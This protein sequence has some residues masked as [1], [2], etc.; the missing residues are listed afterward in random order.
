[1]KT[2]II[3]LSKIII[4]L[5]IVV[6]FNQCKK[7]SPMITP[8]FD[9]ALFENAIW[10]K[11]NYETDSIELYD[12]KGIIYTAA[13]E[14]GQINSLIDKAYEELGSDGGSVLIGQGKFRIEAPIILKSNITIKGVGSSTVI[15]SNSGSFFIANNVSGITVGGLKLIGNIGAGTVTN[16]IEFS[17]DS[18]NNLIQGVSID[19]INGNGIHFS[20]SGCIENVI[21]QNGI[22]NVTGSGIVFTNDACGKIVDNG[23]EST[24]THA[25]LVNGGSNVYITGN[26]ILDAGALGINGNL[27][28]GIKVEST[29]RAV[30]QGN[31]SNS[32]TDAGI[33][34]SNASKVIITKNSISSAS[35]DGIVA[36]SVD[37]ADISENNLF[38]ITGNGILVSG[39]SAAKSVNIFISDN[40]I[41]YPNGAAAVKIEYLDNGTIKNNILVP[42]TNP[43]TIPLFQGTE[44][45]NLVES[46]NEID[47]SN[48]VPLPVLR[49][50]F[51]TT[52]GSYWGTSP[53]RIADYSSG[54]PEFDNGNQWLF[55]AG[56]QG[57]PTYEDCMNSKHIL[58]YE[59]INGK[60]RYALEANPGP[61]IDLGLDPNNSTIRSW[62]PPRDYGL[63]GTGAKTVAF[64][65]K[66]SEESPTRPDGYGSSIITVGLPPWES[67]SPRQGLSIVLVKNNGNKNFKVIF[68]DL[69]TFTVPTALSDNVWYHFVLRMP[70]A[71]AVKD[72]EVLLNGRL[73]SNHNNDL[74]FD[75]PV[76]LKNSYFLWATTWFAHGISLADLRFY[77]QYVDDQFINLMMLQ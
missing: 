30:I 33:I 15:R 32:T 41:N 72:V 58:T 49:I 44:V 2:I 74:A 63:D 52:G 71:G 10:I 62:L 54:F 23:I 9:N 69:V 31:S 48:P 53:A 14:N 19:S 24:G 28:S 20:G 26:S 59:K 66:L 40:K 76:N 64:W 73:V 39:S 65:V 55:D 50:L 35:T 77:N 45:T 57:L 37:S 68:N 43:I 46:A 4:I 25:I 12:S 61:S 18:K 17:G 16:A 34:V 29:S 42:G 51:D 8:D 38:V 11:F 5:F 67:V 70:E 60:F 27:S 47:L 7:E 13:Y 21:K 1:M 6:A 36:V 75:I 56:N 22:S 3:K